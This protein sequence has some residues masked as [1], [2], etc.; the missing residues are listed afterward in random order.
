MRVLKWS[1]AADDTEQVIGGGPVLLVAAQHTPLTVEVWTEE[2]GIDVES[3]R[4]VVVVGTGHE[5]PSAATHLG[6][7][8]AHPFVW[9]VYEVHQP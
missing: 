3:M 5:I 6:S 8:L 2:E 1:V 7:T 9:H 4:H